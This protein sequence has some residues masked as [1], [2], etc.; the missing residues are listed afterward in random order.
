MVEQFESEEYLA[1]V[2]E[3]QGRILGRLKGLDLSGGLY[4]SVWRYYYLAQG[5]S[6]P[7]TL[8]RYA[9]I[10][11]SGKES[12][13]KFKN[14]SEVIK[15]LRDQELQKLKDTPLTDALDSVELHAVKIS[16]LEKIITLYDNVN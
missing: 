16:I 15:I 7:N 5:I 12:K 10:D 8:M 13:I 6:V 1:A 11:Y 4:N 14:P 2:K 9:E 3:M